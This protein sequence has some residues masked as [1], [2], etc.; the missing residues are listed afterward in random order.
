MKLV[1]ALFLLGAVVVSP[2]S[3]HPAAQSSPAS[4]T[5][6]MYRA[7]A[8]SAD[9][10]FRHI[11]TNG[12]S[13]HPDPSPTVLTEREIN[14]YVSSGKVILPKGVSRLRFTGAAGAVTTNASVDFD[15]VTEGKG[16]SNPLMTLFSG[17]H[18]IQV[19]AHAQGTAGQGRVHIDSVYIDGLPVP[20]VALEYFASKYIKPKNPNL[21]I[22]SQFALPDRINTATIGDHVLTIVQR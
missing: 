18:D 3:T 6:A 21:G 11:E 17:V 1:S 8:Q 14:S 12:K 19:A 7:A 2:L 13:S 20:R 9:T 5:E 22:D 15:K 10:K 4:A 16:S